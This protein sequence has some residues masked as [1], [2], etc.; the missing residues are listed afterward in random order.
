M[1]KAPS[2]DNDALKSDL[3]RAL[4]EL[5]DKAPEYQKR[6]ERYDGLQGEVIAHPDLKALLEK[7][8]GDNFRLSIAAVPADVIADRVDLQALTANDDTIDKALATLLWE[9][10]ELD[11]DADDFHLKAAYLGDYYAI[12]WPQPTE[13][14]DDG[15][16]AGAGSVIELHGKHPTVA[17][18]LYSRENARDV[19]FGIFRWQV[20]KEK[21]RV[22]TYYDDVVVQW[23]AEAS[24]GT[25]AEQYELLLDDEGDP[26][27]ID[28]PYGFP[29]FHWRVD[30]KP[31]GRPVNLKAY[32]PQDAITKLVA[33]H[34][35]T[36][37]YQGFPQ[38]Y[39]LLDP[40]REEGDDIADDFNE[41]GTINDDRVDTTQQSKLKSKPG[42]AWLLEGVKAAGQFDPADPKTLL[43]P[44]D[45]YARKA[46]ALCRVPVR[47]F[48]IDDQGND[49]SGESRR[50]E[51]APLTK[52]AKKVAGSFGRTW[53][54]VGAFALKVWGI[55]D[56]KVVRATWAPAELATDKEG[57]ELV[58]LKVKQG[59]PPRQALIEAG[60]PSKEVDKWLPEGTGDD[61]VQWSAE[62]AVFLAPALQAFGQAVTLGA[63]SAD[64][65]AAVLQRLLPPRAEGSTEPQPA[66]P[67]APPR[68]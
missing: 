26:D 25:K 36:V 53:Q 34:M 45:F 62:L 5:I 66:L 7:Y 41:H 14:D 27:L 9:P 13:D 6:Q 3:G 33:T 55:G 20:G 22:N 28:N 67:A 64:Q 16:G 29:M 31:Y 47:Y 43:D 23:R 24:D 15:S 10:N 11:D 37:D 17:R 42:S 57:M 46:A 8:A 2:D 52:H 39:A 32:G 60:Y 61:P 58:A 19:D 12:A 59:V 35:A 56:G 30:S 44:V 68:G 1:A 48:G 38:R 40:S 18:I 65:A 63:I 50:R 4:G 51:D 21:W 54:Q 49:P